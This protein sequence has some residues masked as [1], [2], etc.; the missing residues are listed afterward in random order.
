MVLV[1]DREDK[2]MYLPEQNSEYPYGGAPSVEGVV[3]CTSSSSN[4]L[5]LARATSSFFLPLLVIPSFLLWAGV[6]CTSLERRMWPCVPT[7]QFEAP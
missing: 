7:M 2:I 3:A 4:V 6:S 5:L 1:S